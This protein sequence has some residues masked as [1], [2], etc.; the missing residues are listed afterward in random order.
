MAVTIHDEGSR[1]NRREL[2]MCVYQAGLKGFQNRMVT[3]I[4]VDLRKAL[5]LLIRLI[6]RAKT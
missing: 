2:Q 4:Y 1:M 3:L 6:V 5:D